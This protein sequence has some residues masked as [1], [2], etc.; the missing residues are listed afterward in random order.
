MQSLRD[1]LV[2]RSADGDI[3]AKRSAEPKLS[4]QAWEQEPFHM[5]YGNFGRF[6]WN[7]G[8]IRVEVYSRESIV[9]SPN[10]K[11]KK[12]EDYESRETSAIP[13]GTG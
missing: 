8:A 6:K 10:A 2:L 11:D 13:A 5:E 9:P 4:S 1:A 7:S 3:F 12:W